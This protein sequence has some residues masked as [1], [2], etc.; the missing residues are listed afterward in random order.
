MQITDTDW[1]KRY[2]E[3]DRTL[4]ESQA[5]IDGLIA[6][7]GLNVSDNDEQPNLKKQIRFLW[8]ALGLSWMIT[9]IALFGG[10]YT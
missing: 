2:S 10:F 9:A 6:K 7:D 3:M 4:A 5:V 8:I 1:K